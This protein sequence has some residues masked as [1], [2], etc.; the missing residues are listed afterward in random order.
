MV[1][2]KI[3][4]LL[5]SN[6]IA[7]TYSEHEEVRT[8]EE[9]ARV[10]GTR[11]D[12][13]AKAL[14]L[15]GEKTGKNI[16]VVIPAHKKAN[17]KSLSQIVGETLHF[18]TP[19]KILERWNIQVGGVPPFGNLLGTTTYV[20]RGVLNNENISFNCG[21]RTASIV[22]KSKDLVNLIGGILGDYSQ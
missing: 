7:F 17:L 18:E 22:M 9:A 8:S 16:M 4:T 12:E 13:G 6:N 2:D 15:K 14:I 20:D 21:L 11:L 19:D 1:K 10:R 5:K 3:I